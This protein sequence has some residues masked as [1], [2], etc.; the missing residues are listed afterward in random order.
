MAVAR[1]PSLLRGVPARLA[2]VAM[3]AGAF[4]GWAMWPSAETPSAPA[5]LA[6]AGKHVDRLAFSGDEADIPVRE[7]RIYDTIA[8]F[9][10]PR[11]EP[12][13]WSEA[14]VPATVQEAGIRPMPLRP[15]AMP[16]L[17]A[18]EAARRPDAAR[19]ARIAAA[20]HV[21]PVQ[22]NRDLSE[23]VRVFGWTVP[24]SEH[25]PTRR[26]AAHVLGKVGDGAVAVGSG[27]A[28]LV[29]RSA[30]AVGTGLASAKT[31]LAET[32]GLD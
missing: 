7:A 27:T 29:S 4:A 30:T 31:A 15:V 20:D 11:T 19:P 23:P 6:L 18:A 1:L 24:G 22:A 26:D 5:A 17:A 28:N 13:P 12:R 21:R 9:A 25:L 10:Q 16:R 32:L 2:A 8:M 14:P 3:V